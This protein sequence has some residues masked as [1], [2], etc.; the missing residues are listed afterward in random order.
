MSEI[1]TLAAIKASGT[2]S[3]AAASLGVSQPSLSQHLRELEEKLQLPLFERRNRGLEPT[4]FGIVLMGVADAMGLE[5]RGAAREMVRVAQN[6]DTPLRIGS[7]AVAS[8]GLLAAAVSRYVG[9]VDASS[10]TVIEGPKESLLEHLR[11]SRIDLYVG[12]LGHETSADLKVEILFNDSVTVIA[13]EDHPLVTRKSSVN[14]ALLQRYPWILPV[15]ESSFNWQLKESF[16]KQGIEVRKPKVRSFSTL[17]IAAMVAQSEMI[18]FL[19]TSLYAAGTLSLRLRRVPVRMSWIPFP[20]GVVALKGAGS[21]PDGERFTHELRL[22]SDTIFRS[23]VAA[24]T[25]LNGYP[26]DQ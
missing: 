18:G 11:H 10:V 24:D 3:R 13:S 26:E 5:L 22:V 12:R 8:G 7:M 14:I 6:H 25:K 16:R 15:E 2:L 20:V 23:I 19:P 17:A 9:Q 4:G 1:R 21:H